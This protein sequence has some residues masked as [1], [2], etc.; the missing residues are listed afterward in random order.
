VR[1]TISGEAC[2]AGLLRAGFRIHRRS[3][4]VSVLKRE[5]RLVM[6]PD[7]EALSPDMVDAIVRS[8]G[9]TLGELDRHLD[10]APTRSGWFTRAKV[11]GATADA[12]EDKASAPASSRGKQR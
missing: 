3:S 12:T 11:D 9:M 8:A 7:V 2:A 10:P 1:R 4:G 5:A 6:I